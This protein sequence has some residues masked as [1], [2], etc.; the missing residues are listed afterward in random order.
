MSALPVRSFCHVLM[1]RTI[2]D[3]LDFFKT[4]SKQGSGGWIQPILQLSIIAPLTA[5][6]QASFCS[7]NCQD[8]G[9]NI[10]GIFSG[11]LPKISGVLRLKLGPLENKWGLFSVKV[12]EKILR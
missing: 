6:V 10:E 9:R 5:E 4:A 2:S 1:V 7:E 3:G 8:S 12:Y 11:G